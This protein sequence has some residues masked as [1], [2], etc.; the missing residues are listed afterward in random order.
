MIGKNKW[1]P[2]GCKKKIWVL[3]I[4][5]FNVGKTIINHPNLGMVNTYTNCDLGDGLLLVCPHYIV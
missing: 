1:I 3:K 5:W 4:P 2:V